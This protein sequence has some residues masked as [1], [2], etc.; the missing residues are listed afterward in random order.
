[1]VKFPI[2]RK[3]WEWWWKWIIDPAVRNNNALKS[4]WVIKWKKARVV[5]FNPRLVIIT[6]SWDKVD[7]AIIFFISHSAMAALPA[8]NIVIVAI[9]KSVLL[10]NGI[11]ERA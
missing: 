11:W 10:K 7:R 5:K 3:S 8:I 2:K 1:M 4:A 6:P 9:I